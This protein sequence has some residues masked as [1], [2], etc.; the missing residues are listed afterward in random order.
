M[1]SQFNTLIRSYHD[2]FLQYKLTGNESYQKSYQSAQQGIETIL[3]SLESQNSN[4]RSDI[5]NFYNENV[6]G[7]LRDIRSKK[8]DLQRN[9]LADN[10]EL[11][12]AQ[13]RAQSSGVS[14][15]PSMTNRYIALGVMSLIA[16]GLMAMRN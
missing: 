10:D 6:E 14:V 15:E 13:M 7:R 4:Q 9:L 2:N 11:V 5:S 8:Q 12:A 3:S 1:D 16:F